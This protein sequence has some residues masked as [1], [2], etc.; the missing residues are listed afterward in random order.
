MYSLNVSGVLQMTLQDAIFLLMIL[1]LT[2]KNK[3]E[4]RL[5]ILSPVL[6]R[7]ARNLEHGCPTLIMILENIL[8]HRLANLKKAFYGYSS[9][10]Y[11]C[12]H[13]VAHNGM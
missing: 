4:L 11:I 13:V 7:S 10:Y 12:F 3:N 9:M 2:N 1:K 5:V 6:K 8:V